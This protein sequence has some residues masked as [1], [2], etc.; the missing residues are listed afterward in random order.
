MRDYIFTRQRSTVALFF[1]L[2]K[3]TITYKRSFHILVNKNSETNCTFSF[4]D[5]AGVNKVDSSKKKSLVTDSGLDLDDGRLI[6]NG[7]SF[8]NSSSNGSNIVVTIG[9]RQSVPAIR[10]ETLQDIFSERDFSR[11]INGDLVVIVQS[12]ELAEL[13]VTKGI[14]LLL[15]KKLPRLSSS[16]PNKNN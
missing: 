3:R 7:L 11:T 8:G 5:A 4:P 6:G 9:D 16:L 13:P 12:N 1:T 15:A 14:N 2:Q 10:F